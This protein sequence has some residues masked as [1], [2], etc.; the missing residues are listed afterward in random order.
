LRFLGEILQAQ[1]WLTRPKQQK[2]GP[3]IFDPDPSLLSNKFDIKSQV[4][5]ATKEN[6]GETK[7]SYVTNSVC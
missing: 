6:Q 7:Q 2:I 3:K 1:R 5:L 4:P